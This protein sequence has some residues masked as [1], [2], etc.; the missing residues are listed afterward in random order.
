MLKDV[1]AAINSKMK[2]ACTCCIQC[3]RCEQHC[4]QHIE[5]RRELKNARRKL[6][7]PLYKIA[8]AVVKLMK[9]Y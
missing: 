5:I 6:E 1:V 2:V 3:G 9:A 7:G 8:R 4:P